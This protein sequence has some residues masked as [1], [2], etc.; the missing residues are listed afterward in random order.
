MPASKKNNNLKDNFDGIILHGGVDISP[1]MYNEKQIVP[2]MGVDEERDT[3]EIKIIDR[4]LSH[5]IPILGICRGMQM[6]NVFLGGSLYQDIT[7]QLPNSLKHRCPN[8]YEQNHHSINLV[9]GS[10]LHSLY[11]LTEAKVNSVH[12]QGIKKLGRGLKVQARSSPDQIIESIFLDSTE[13]KKSYF[14]GV[15]WHPEFQTPEDTSLLDQ[16]TI[17]DDFILRTKNT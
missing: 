14:L 11:G 2:L 1:K 4:C 3:F 16:E 5:N 9:K 13:Y 8:L 10:H 6:V 17:F 12:H 15:Q 7:T